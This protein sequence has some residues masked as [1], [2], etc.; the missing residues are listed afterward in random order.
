MK[1]SSLLIRNTFTL[2]ELLVV[3]AIIAILASILLPALNNARDRGK[4]INCTNNLKQIG[5]GIALYGGDNKGRIPLMYSKNWSD[6]RPIPYILSGFDRNSGIPNTTAY[7]PSKVLLCPAVGTWSSTQS[8]KIYGVC[9]EAQYQYIALNSG[10]KALKTTGSASGNEY[11]IHRLKRPAQYI[12]VFDCAN[13]NGAYEIAITNKCGLYTL[14][15]NCGNIVFADG[16]VKP[17]SENEFR[18][19]Y[20]PHTIVTKNNKVITE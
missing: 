2:I 12:T 5:T 1:N 16:H 13:L 7:L 14:H 4:A 18:S 3:I 17:L 11:V 19:S 8:S 6:E 15:S 9:Y 10:D 20:T